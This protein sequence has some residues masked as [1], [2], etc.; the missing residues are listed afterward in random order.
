M[1]EMDDMKWIFSLKPGVLNFMDHLKSNAVEGYYKYSLSGDLLDE[2]LHWNIGSSIFSLKIYYTLGIEYD[3]H[4]EKICRYILSFRKGSRIY[5]EY[6]LKQNYQ[7]KRI[8]YNI[9]KQKFHQLFNFHRHYKNAET[10]QALSALLLYNQLPDIE[11]ADLPLS[12]SEIN[13]YLCR[14]NWNNPW[15]AGSHFSHLIFFYKVQLFN[16]RIDREAYSKMTGTAINWLDRIKNPDG[17]WYLGKVSET[18]KVNGA[19]KIFSGYITAD[20]YELA[21]A[22]KLMDTVLNVNTQDHACDYFNIVHVVYYLDKVLKGTYNK[23]LTARFC[24]KKLKEY[25]DFYY[26]T[27]G[28]FSF[29]RQ[30]SDTGYYGAR[31]TRG[32]NEP[33]MHGTVLF[34][35]GIAMISEIL[36]VHDQ[37]QF[38]VFDS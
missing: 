16:G 37:I 30:K 13:R 7:L 25:R 19:M 22:K 36:G 14:L 6:V 10:R 1:A 33:D 24:M 2:N 4:I 23:E 5:S 26:D 31:V 9:Y 34:L 3:D 38:N 17:F 15:S 28:G 11:L 18:M 29:N 32:L 27:K 20:Y 8:V 21:N 35:W 12:E